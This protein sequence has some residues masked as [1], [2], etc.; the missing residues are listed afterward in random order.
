[1]SAPFE[2]Q[3]T[4][5][6]LRVFGP[7]ATRMAAL[8]RARPTLLN[9]LA[10]APA[11]AIHSVAAFLYFCAEAN[12]LPDPDVARI[13]DE[14]H[15]RQL[16]H[17]AIPDAPPA[18]YK[19]LDKAGDRVHERPFYER[20]A[21]AC[22][23]PL[24]D[25]L[26]SSSKKIDNVRLHWAETLLAADPAILGMSAMLT[27]PLHKVL[28]LD[29]ML[30]FLR[31]HD[32]FRPADFELPEAADL[33][34]ILKRLCVALDRV[35]APPQSFS[36][37]APFRFV[38]SVGEL[39]AICLHLRNRGRNFRCRGTSHWFRLA[40]G[41]TVYVTSDDPLMLSAV[42]RVGRSIWTIDEVDAPKSEGNRAADDV[43]T[44]LVD[45]LHQAGVRLVQ[46][47]PANVLGALTGYPGF[48]DDGD[49]DPGDGAVNAALVA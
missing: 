13:L 30:A 6:V 16:L 12:A 25:K 26:L 34:A 14:R 42:R 39:R 32:A 37:P 17:A 22:S 29:I 31:D 36:I 10:F 3:E 2:R 27:Q 19:A 9:R 35:K 20:L 21:A 40:K 45:A 15:P 5:P 28:A 4:A 44:L 38:Q 24:A 8:L 47:D 46:E 49:D 18:L 11:R 23:G 7:H 48:E 33:P 43:R 1:M 41:M